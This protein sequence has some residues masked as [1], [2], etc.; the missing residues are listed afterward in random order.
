MKAT[1][2]GGLALALA[3]SGPTFADD[4]ITQALPTHAAALVEVPRE[5]R[6][7]GTVEAVN[8]S[9]VTAQTSGQIDE[10]LFDVDD[11]VEQGD[12][13]LRLRDTEQR[14]RMAQ[15]KAELS[16]SEAR[17]EEAEDE[18][19]RTEQ[20]FAR[21]LVPEASMDKATTALDSARA[22]AEAARAAV[23]QAREQL[24]YTLVRAPY[25]GIVTHRHVQIGEVANPGQPLMTGVSLDELRVTVDVPQT[26][27]PL[28]R[29]MNKAAV[30]DPGIG[31][32]DARKI[33]VFPY[34]DYGSNTFKVRLD[35][36]PGTQ[37]L[38]PGMFVKV[39][40]VTGFSHEL[41]VPR[42]AV[43]FRSEVTG[44]YVVDEEGH[45]HLRHIRIGRELPNGTFIVLSGL[46]P[47]ERVAMDPIAAGV[48]VK[49]GRAERD[50]E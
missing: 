13:I 28:V 49:R 47:G 11:Y 14:A 3:L 40:F 16:A 15:A 26:L 7:D 23:D 45:P 50:D 4:R 6:L 18:H 19:E 27:V 29:D 39:A 41:V 36:P 37:N 22:Q 1:V 9:T 17:L 34:A 8:Q 46:E 5:Y 43:V 32:V 31:F 33:T 20:L 30:L 12:L 21:E 42:S 24:E 10:I 44:V 25:T 35:L 38:F 2:F 48:M